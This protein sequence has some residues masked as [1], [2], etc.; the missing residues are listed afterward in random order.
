MPWIREATVSDARDDIT[1]GAR[2]VRRFWPDESAPHA[3]GDSFHTAEAVKFNADGW[4]TI[5]YVRYTEGGSKRVESLHYAPDDVVA[6]AAMGLVYA[7][8][9]MQT[10]AHNDSRLFLPGGYMDAHPGTMHGVWDVY[11]ADGTPLAEGVST[12]EGRELLA[13]EAPAMI[14]VH[15]GDGKWTAR[16]HG[17]AW[18]IERDGRAPDYS[19]RTSP[20]SRYWLYTLSSRLLEGEEWEEVAQGCATAEDAK[21]AAPAR[22]A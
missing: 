12:A 3:Y 2:L 17:R 10:Y 15:H 22:T 4:V 20:L 13:A 9:N 21:G 1:V 18:R 16:G 6:I 11:R 5:D 8:G 7:G 19:P 14:W